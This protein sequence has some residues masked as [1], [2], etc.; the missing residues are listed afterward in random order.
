MCDDFI[1]TY[2]FTIQLKINMP[3]HDRTNCAYSFF[4]SYTLLIENKN[5]SCRPLLS[6]QMGSVQATAISECIKLENRVWL[7]DRRNPIR[8]KSKRSGSLSSVLRQVR[9]WRECWRRWCSWTW[10]SWW[11]VDCVRSSSKSVKWTRR[12]VSLT[13]NAATSTMHA[14]SRTTQCCAGPGTF[15]SWRLK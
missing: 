9:F 3:L 11:S 10:R 12:S 4:G 8:L 15:R 14:C 1:W 13:I 2:L 5:F 6:K 7:T